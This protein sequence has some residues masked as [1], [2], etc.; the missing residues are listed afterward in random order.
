VFSALAELQHVTEIK[1]YIQCAIVQLHITGHHNVR[2]TIATQSVRKGRE[3]NTNKRQAC[4]TYT[5]RT[6]TSIENGLFNIHHL[7][8]CPLQLKI[9][10]I[11]T[12]DTLVLSIKWSTSRYTAAVTMTSISSAGNTLT[13]L[14]SIPSPRTNSTPLAKLSARKA[15]RA[16]LCIST[17]A[18][19]NVV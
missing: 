18:G 3:L 6:N 13:S 19:N 11:G 14:A 5:R 12:L 2:V 7:L 9:V 17:F 4:S 1:S 10:K 8:L 15:K 16:Q